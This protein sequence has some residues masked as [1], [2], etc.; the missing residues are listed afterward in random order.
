MREELGLSKSKDDKVDLNLDDKASSSC[1]K[2]LVKEKC[3]LFVVLGRKLGQ[4]L[5]VERY[6]A[7]FLPSK[8][9]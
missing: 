1:T 3:N 9:N 2:F 7:G 6:E 8:V 4:R 5:K